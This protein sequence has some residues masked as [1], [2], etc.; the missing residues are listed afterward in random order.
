MKSNL[1]HRLI[2]LL[3]FPVS[4]IYKLAIRDRMPYSDPNLPP[5][6]HE[7]EDLWTERVAADQPLCERTYYG[8]Q[9]LVPKADFFPAVGRAPRVAMFRRRV[10]LY[11]RPTAW[12]CSIDETRSTRRVLR[13]Y[14]VLQ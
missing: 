14:V 11:E 9:R 8:G 1:T 13:V 3:N 7:V 6:S 4:P 5:L 12:P 2:N 10:R